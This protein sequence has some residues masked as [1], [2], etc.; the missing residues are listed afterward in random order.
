M[1][2]RT[3]QGYASSVAGY[4]HDYAMEDVLAGGYLLAEEWEPELVSGEMGTQFSPINT[5]IPWNH[6]K[7]ES[8]LSVVHCNDLYAI[9]R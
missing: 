4:L 5:F 9:L 7:I 8:S 1:I 3:K 2:S 6:V